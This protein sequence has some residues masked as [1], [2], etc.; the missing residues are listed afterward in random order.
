MN[1]FD[2]FIEIGTQLSLQTEQTNV[3]NLIQKNQYHKQ[4]KQQMISFVK[5]M[6]HSLDHDSTVD[7]QVI[8]TY[9]IPL[10]RYLCLNSYL[11]EYTRD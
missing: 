2:R 3:W 5:Q 10:L 11:R 4:H 9:I 1:V 7:N 8:L 6:Y